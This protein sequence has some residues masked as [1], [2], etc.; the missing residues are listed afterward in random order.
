MHSHIVLLG[1]SVA[2]RGA[3]HSGQYLTGGRGC[4][5]QWFLSRI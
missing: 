4:I 2:P 3:E 1:V 5:T